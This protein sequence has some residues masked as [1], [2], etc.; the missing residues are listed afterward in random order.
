MNLIKLSQT[1]IPFPGHLKEYEYDEEEVLKGLKKSQVNSTESATS[2]KK[3]VKEKTRIEEEIKATMNEH[4]LEIIK[5]GLPPKEKDPWIFTLP[6]KI[7]DMRFDKALAD[8]GPSVSVMSYSTFTNL[9]LVMENMDA[10]RDKEG[11]IIFGKPICR[12]ACVEARRFDG[13]ITIYNDND[14]VT[15]QMA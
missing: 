6:C 15:Y 11:D 14:N 1:S 4:Y 3:F 9:G 5:D 12:D 8:L 2:L 13:F 10:Y 7:N